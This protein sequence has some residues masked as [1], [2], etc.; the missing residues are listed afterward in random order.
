MI[1]EG[2]ANTPL[3][4]YFFYKQSTFISDAGT[5]VCYPI[6][7]IAD[8]GNGQLV[9]TT[10]D[11][12]DL[13]VGVAVSI[14][15]TTSYNGNYTVISLTPTTFNVSGIF[16]ATEAGTWEL[17]SSIT[18]ANAGDPLDFGKIF[19]YD[20]T[21]KVTLLNTYAD[22]DLTVPNPNPY[23]L[24]AIGSAP[25]FYLLSQPYYIEIFDKFN[26]LVATLDNYLPDADES[27][28][29]TELPL[30][31]LFSNYGFDT[32]VNSNIY[33]RDSVPSGGIAVS[34]GWIWEIETTET[35]PRNT[36]KYLELAASGLI[37]NPKNELI[38]KS[39]NNTSGQTVDRL[40][41]VIGT[42]NMFQGQQLAL[43]IYTRLVSGTTDTLPIQLIRTKNGIEETPISVGSISIVASQTQETL[44]FT[45]PALSTANY[46]NN[47]ELRLAINLPLNEDFEH[48]FTGTW[49]QLSPSGSLDISETAVSTSTVKQ[50]AGLGSSEMGLNDQYVMRGLPWAMG[51]SSFFTLA[52][53]G[54]IFAAAPNST[55]FNSFAAS[56]IAKGDED[57]GVQLVRN[58]VI[59]KTQTNRLIDYLRDNNYIQSRLTFLASSVA[60]VVTV[61]PGIGSA[62]N[63]PWTSSA[64]VTVLKT[65]DE[66]QYKLSVT[67]T[68][69]GIVVFEFVD[70]FAATTTG[71]NPL[72]SDAVTLAYSQLPPSSPIIDWFG[73]TNWN[74]ASAN[75]QS[76]FEPFFSQDILNAGSAT[77]SAKVAIKF[78]DNQPASVNA[79]SLKDVGGAQNGNNGY[80]NIN[81][82]RSIY[83]GSGNIIRTY[84]NLPADINV[85]IGQS[86]LA[87]NDVSLN[88]NPQLSIPPRTIRFL[89]Q[90]IASI[91]PTGSLSNVDVPLNVGETASQVAEKISSTVNTKW[92]QTITIDSTPANGETIQM[93]NAGTDINLIFWDTSLPQPTNPSTIR[94]PIYVQF[95]TAQTTTQIA[96]STA[97]ALESGIMGVPRAADLG[98]FFPD[99]TQFYMML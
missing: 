7:S 62:Q 87:Y 56:M 32:T 72:Y 5:P 98:M 41:S 39:T 2:L 92:T 60:N 16:G 84:I 37:A 40:Y 4:N 1:N 26:N 19:F 52:T 59:G 54:T 34:A 38:L 57:F 43:S 20:Q 31:N 36:Y 3:I 10:S 96:A 91:A 67:T 30:D 25:P 8:G 23:I 86:Y 9:I 78:L 76:E 44:I 77:E 14:A 49:L 12:S 79:E 69:N 55:Q 89:V 24:D 70:N 97:D 45:V 88:P 75:R 63:S 33:G 80:E 15:A 94:E 22:R 46:D 48:G 93:S 35:S 28:P 71:H 61:Q 47:D 74:A 66:F 73:D 68:G 11:T 21:D 53:T 85:N 13:T 82:V 90:G 50:L 42:Y 64:N 58:Q 17:A 29:G 83:R 65:I 6:L 27:L 95:S 99:N 18:G 51:E 81:R